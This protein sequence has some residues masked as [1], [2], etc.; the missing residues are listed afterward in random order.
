MHPYTCVHMC[1]RMYIY[2]Y[3]MCC[4]YCIYVL[5]CLVCMIL[6]RSQTLYYVRTYVL[7]QLVK[8]WIAR[9]KGLEIPISE[10]VSVVSI[11]ADAYEIRQWNASGLP[12]DNVS[13]IAFDILNST[14]YAVHVHVY[15]V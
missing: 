4:M 15:Y 7:V 14:M 12:R 1:V 10:D 6:S 13:M 9:C 11:L 3:C 8:K 5:V 2:A